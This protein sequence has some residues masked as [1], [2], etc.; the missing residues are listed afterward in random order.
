MQRGAA[1][2]AQLKLKKRCKEV[3]E[4]RTQMGETSGKRCETA[5]ESKVYRE[6]ALTEQ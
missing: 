2:G 3:V 6:A 5:N 4:H 1:A